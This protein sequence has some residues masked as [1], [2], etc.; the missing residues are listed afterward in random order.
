M[1]AHLESGA[2]GRNG[3]VH[4]PGPGVEVSLMKSCLRA[5]SGVSIETSARAAAESDWEDTDDSI[6][7]NDA[8]AHLGGSDQRRHPCVGAVALEWGSARC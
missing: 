4:V 5:K 3:A 2:A 1:T 7:L 8:V 6:E